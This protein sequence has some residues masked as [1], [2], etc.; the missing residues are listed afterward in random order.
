MPPRSPSRRTDSRGRAAASARAARVLAAL[1]DETRL[2][3][4]GSLCAG[5]AVSIAELTAGTQISRQAVTKHLQ[6][7]ADAGLASDIRD[8]RERLW[9]FEPRAL[10]AAM[11]SLALVEQQWR[12]AILRTTA[13]R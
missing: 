9:Q 5:G 11:K 4:V 10:S 1:G 13:G 2:A 12:K 7:L 6:V 8:G 3:L